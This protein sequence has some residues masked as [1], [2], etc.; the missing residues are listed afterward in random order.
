VGYRFL[1]Q[2]ILC[3]VIKNAMLSEG[4][5][6]EAMK[7]SSVFEWDKRSKL[8]HKNVE[9]N[10]SSGRPRLQRNDENVEVQNLVHSG[11]RLSIRAVAVQLNLDKETVNKARTLVK[12]LD[13][14]P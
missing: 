9:C 1:H 5:W 10:E 2:R 8:S 12:L 14:P 4:L 3:E 7:M 11:R 6:G 13:S